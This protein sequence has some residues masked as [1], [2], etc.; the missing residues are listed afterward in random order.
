MANTLLL[1]YISFWNG[2]GARLAETFD[3]IRMEDLKIGVTAD[4][5]IS[6]W[7]SYVSNGAGGSCFG[8]DTRAILA[9]AGSGAISG[10][11]MTSPAPS[12]CAARRGST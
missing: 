7:G 3:N 10:G 4:A 11:R 9:T 6:T 2:V 8:K 1:T 12:A 5:R